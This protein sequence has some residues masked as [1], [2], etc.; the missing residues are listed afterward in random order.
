MKLKTL[1]AAALALPLATSCLGPNHAHDGIRNWNATATE[2]EWVNEIIFLGLH[3]I[4]VY[5]LAYAG[6]QLIFN[7]VDYWTGDNPMD[8]PGAFPGESFG[9]QP[10]E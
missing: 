9:K 4:P 7:T 1:A 10:G 3:I 2:T 6:D 5:P 8:D